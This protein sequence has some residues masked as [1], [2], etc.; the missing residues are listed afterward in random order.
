MSLHIRLTDSPEKALE[1]LRAP[2]ELAYLTMYGHEGE[3][4]VAHPEEFMDPRGGLWTAYDGSKL[5]GIAGWTDIS[6]LGYETVPEARS[7][8]L[9]RLFVLPEY[10]GKLTQE[11]DRWRLFHIFTSGFDLAV[12]ETGAPQK[13]SKV[14]H[15]RFPYHEEK[16]YG[17]YADN[18]GSFF[19]GCWKSDWFKWVEETWIR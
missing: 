10:R 3:S 19:F 14:A 4:G 18:P 2:L 15:S 1:E 16:P 7:A 17:R 6:L 8:E 13:A 11:L 9:K 5:V 12:G